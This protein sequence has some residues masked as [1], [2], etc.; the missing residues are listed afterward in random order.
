VLARRFQV[1]LV[2][3]ALSLTGC[4]RGAAADPG[5]SQWPAGAAGQVC[6][7]LEYDAVATKLGVRFDTAGGGEKDGTA[8]CALTQAGHEYPYLTLAMTP[9][10]ADEVIFVATVEPSGSSRVKGLGL[11]AYRLNVAATGKAGPAIE[12]GWLSPRERLM[13]LR[14]AFAP[15]ADRDTLNLFYPKLLALAKQAEKPVTAG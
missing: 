13:I 7:L 2:L 8:T 12:I 15:G 14:Y 3:V 5:L 1:G 10:K 9:T 11:I 4:D 6:Q